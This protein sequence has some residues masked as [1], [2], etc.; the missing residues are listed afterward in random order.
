[1]ALRGAKKRTKDVDI[2]LADD[3]AFRLTE[4][5]LKRAGFSPP[6]GR[7]I[8]YER[9]QAR[10]I[11]EDTEGFS[12]DLFVENVAGK[13]RLTASV[14]RR[15]SQWSKTG[16]VVVLLASDEDIFLSK[17]ATGR[18]GD[19]D[20][21]AELYRGGLNERVLIEEC[22]RQDEG[23]EMLWESFLAVRLDELEEHA[24]LTVP[25]KERVRR[26][27]ERKLA[28]HRIITLL[29]EGSHTTTELADK[30]FVDARFIR[31]IVSK[32]ETEGRIRVDRSQRPY[33]CTIV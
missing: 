24:D 19:L 7:G 22:Q 3:A 21:M 13:F 14:L 17:A 30:L 10:A 25:W 29:S 32:L 28:E 8:E 31:H 11:L 9:L 20:D 4:R 26:I 23:S 2:V 15:A 18:R 33:R 27:A 1:M 12:F 16:Q 6:K 5:A